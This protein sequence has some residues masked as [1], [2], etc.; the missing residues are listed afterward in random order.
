MTNE[1]RFIAVNRNM[2]DANEQRLIA[3]PELHFSGGMLD[4]LKLTGFAV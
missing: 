1:Y 3:N 4:G 2:Y